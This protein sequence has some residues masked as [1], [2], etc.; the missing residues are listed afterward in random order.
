MA[1]PEPVW[2]LATEFSGVILGGGLFVNTIY[3]FSENRVRNSRR[4]HALLRLLHDEF[5]YFSGLA[6]HLGRRARQARQEL[7]PDYSVGA[8]P[9]PAEEQDTLP[10]EAAK[11][12][13]WLVG[14]AEHLANYKFSADIESASSMLSKNQNDALLDFLKAHRIYTEVLM[15]RTLDL[16]SFPLKEGVFVRFVGA[17]QLNTDEVREALQ[18]FKGSLKHAYQ[19]SSSD[20]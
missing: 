15:T 3:M 6:E 11:L 16:K 1:D 8:Y 13:Q 19:K 4:R 14:R 7:F 18:V 9:N 12:S 5:S 10:R 20:A 2:R 17:A